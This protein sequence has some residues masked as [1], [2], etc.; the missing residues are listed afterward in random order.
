MVSRWPWR[1]SLAAFMSFSTSASVRYSRVRMSPL[2]GRL[3]VTVRFT[4]AGVTSLRRDFAIV[5][6]LRAETTVGTTSD[7][8]N[9][10]AHAGCTCRQLVLACDFK[11]SA[12][13][14]DLM[15]QPRVVNRQRRLRRKCLGS[16][17]APCLGGRSISLLFDATKNRLLL[18]RLGSFLQQ[19]FGFSFENPIVVVL[20]QFTYDSKSSSNGL[21]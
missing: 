12:L 19:S 18:T 11:L 10:V 1:L 20:I 15:E 14:L 5:F 6:A 8:Q 13:I 21:P 9:T 7:H 16:H 4:V 17:F 2:G 3:G